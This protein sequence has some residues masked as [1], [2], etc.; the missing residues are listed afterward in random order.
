MN[1]VL[2]LRITVIRFFPLKFYEYYVFLFY[3]WIN[4]AIT[5]WLAH[6]ATYP[7][8]VLASAASHPA[9]GRLPLK[10]GNPPHMSPSRPLWYA[11][12]VSGG[13]VEQGATSQEGPKVGDPQVATAKY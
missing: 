2:Q 11:G 5:P 6:L 13:P 7:P 10:P 1:A 9:G 12:G 8:L 4:I 3:Y